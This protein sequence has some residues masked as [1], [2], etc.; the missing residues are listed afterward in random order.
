MLPALQFAAKGQGA[1]VVAAALA[2]VAYWKAYVP[3]GHGEHEIENPAVGNVWKRGTEPVMRLES[4]EIVLNV[5]K[6]TSA[7][8]DG[9]RQG[10]RACKHIDRCDSPD[11]ML[12]WLK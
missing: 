5:T 7:E 9:R 12:I 3:F 11:E 6:L 2:V 4:R 8:G 1:H 10:G